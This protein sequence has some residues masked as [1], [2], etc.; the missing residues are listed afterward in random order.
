MRRSLLI[1]VLAVLALLA[2][3]CAEEPE[4]GPTEAAG[5]P[6]AGEPTGGTETATADGGQTAAETEPEASPT[7]EPETEYETEELV[8]G[9][10]APNQIYSAMYVAQDQ[11]WFADEAFD[12]SIVMTQSSTGSIQ[13]AAA[14][15]VH[16]AG[17]VP[18]AAVLGIQQGAPVSI[19]AV[20]IKGSPLGVVARP[21]IEGWEDLR[22]QT[23]GVSALAGGEYA[24]LRRLLAEHGL[25]EGDYDVVI[26]GP[27]PAKAAALNEG[28]VAAAVLFS[29]ADYNLEAQGF[30][31]L[32]NTAE[33]PLTDQV[34]LAVYVVNDAW[35]QE[36]DRGERLARVLVRAN[37]WLQDPANR[38]QAVEIFAQA[39]EQPAEHVAT[40]FE[41]WFDELD[42]GT[43]DGMVTTEEIQN[44]ID[45]MADDGE[46]SE[47]L[48]EPEEF[49]DPSYIE[50][51]SSQAGSG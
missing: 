14:G 32:G 25:A 50:A 7:S 24:L 20:A 17:G 45:M 5:G 44:V 40:T 11:G 47:P 46:L 10:V 15:S 23:V 2:A 38:D 28:S 19:M 35:A 39:A 6:T 8:I 22:G 33:L 34:P 49:V 27:T 4:A 41:F 30:R 43:P 26:A 37:Q 48:P 29:P 18:D 42:I 9:L 1:A 36:N 13:Q 12:A 51:A 3:A 21:D 31:I 16:V